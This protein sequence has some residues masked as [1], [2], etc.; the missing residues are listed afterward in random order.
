MGDI[1]INNAGILRDV[2]FKRMTAK[3]WDMIM[4]VHLKGAYAVTKAAWKHMQEQKY[5]RIVNV[6]SPAGLYGNVGQ[7]N[8]STAKMGL[9]GFTQTLA[10]EGARSKIQANIIAPLAGT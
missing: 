3:D 6:A 2:S 9:V 1:V 10:K 4:L 5:G 7:A 8:Y